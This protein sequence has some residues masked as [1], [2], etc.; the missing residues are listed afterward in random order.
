MVNSVDVPVSILTVRCTIR[1]SATVLPSKGI[2]DIV[3]SVGVPRSVIAVFRLGI[4][5]RSGV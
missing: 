2:Y 3:H 1:N 4:L 5:P